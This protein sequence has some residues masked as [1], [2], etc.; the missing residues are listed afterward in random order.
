MFGFHPFGETNAE[1]QRQA[2]ASAAAMDAS[3]QRA[4]QRSAASPVE[5]V[6]YSYQELLAEE[7]ADIDAL[8]KH[9]I[10]KSEFNRRY[11]EILKSMGVSL[12]VLTGDGKGLK[13]AQTRAAQMFAQAMEQQTPTNDPFSQF[14]KASIDENLAFLGSITDREKYKGA[15][16]G[17]FETISRGLQYMQGKYGGS[18]DKQTIQK[19]NQAFAALDTFISQ[20]SDQFKAVLAEA[21]Y[22]G[23]RV[24]PAAIDAGTA[25]EGLGQEQ[26]AQDAAYDQYVKKLTDER[27][28]LSARLGA[29]SQAVQKITAEL[30][31]AQEQQ[32]QSD[33]QN[34]DVREKYNESTATDKSQ[35]IA[36]KIKADGELV[37]L[38]FRYTGPDKWQKILEALAQQNQDIAAQAQQHLQDIQLSGDVRTSSIQTLGPAGDLARLQ[39]QLQTARQKLAAAYSEAPNQN[40]HDDILNAQREVNDLNLQIA[41]TVQT[42]QQNADKIAQ[43]LYDSQ[44]AIKLA[45]AGDDPIAKD[46]LTIQQDTHD[47]QS[48]NPRDFQTTAEYQAARNKALAKVIGDR[49]QLVTDHAQR[50]LDNAKFEHDIGQLTDQQYIS[51]LRKILEMKQLT[52]QM[53]QSILLQIYQ[54]QHQD[55]G[56]LELNAPGGIRAPSMYEVV[57]SMRVNAGRRVGSGAIVASGPMIHQTNHNT[58][59]FNFRGGSKSE[60]GNAIAEALDKAT[61]GSAIANLRAAGAI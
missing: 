29:N 42:Q 15:G 47:L 44:M 2:G 50:D 26:R 27:K 1:S 31:Q 17:D 3:I 11:A 55:Q 54:L 51:Q 58:F 16:A 10:S 39:S 57:K 52:T 22:A 48:I 20:Q 59:N 8:N 38:A 6:G 14:D 30:A 5:Q 23:P 18:Q 49:R 56:A 40:K 36:D 41:Q 46:R 21:R 9:H 12:D 4:R 28:K 24:N 33:V 53:R 19:L 35:A 37:Q 61:G 43:D 25:I 45:Q 32:Y 60:I 13:D 34:I 7:Q